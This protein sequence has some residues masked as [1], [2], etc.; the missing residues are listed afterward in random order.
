MTFY[1][2]VCKTLPANQGLNM[3]PE[4]CFSCLLLL[5][6]SSVI[7]AVVKWLYQE[8]KQNQF[9]EKDLE[10]LEIFIVYN[11]AIYITDY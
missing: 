5:S 4:P 10:M 6:S 2:I 11:H 9:Y 3:G 7:S 1:Y 8:Q